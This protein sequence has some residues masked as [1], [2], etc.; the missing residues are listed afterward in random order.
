MA[1]THYVF[2]GQKYGSM[3]EVQRAI[4]ATMQAPASFA[5]GIGQV[6]PTTY[7]PQQP[8]SYQQ[9]ISYAPAPISQQQTL[10]YAAPMMQQAASYAPSLVQQQTMQYVEA[11]TM[12]Q[13]QQVFLQP[14][15]QHMFQFPQQQQQQHQQQQQQPM[16]YGAPMAQI[17]PV[18]QEAIVKQEVGPWQICEDPMGEYYV[19]T[20]SGQTFDQP[21]AELMQVLQQ[22]GLC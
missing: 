7:A 12:A 5:P 3:E 11:P 1:T 19:Y 2:N 8:V 10:T 15:Q 9:P 18:A 6:Q 13:Q 20:P 17:Q 4:Q 22:H 16:T 14:Q 21:P